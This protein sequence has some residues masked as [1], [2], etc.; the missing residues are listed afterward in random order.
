MSMEIG[1]LIIRILFGA[2]IT[3]HGAQKLFGVFGGYG[4][5][6]TG[7]FFE[8]IGFRPGKPSAAMAGL[9]EFGGGVLL[10]LGLFTPIGAAAILATMT[11]AIF[12]VHWKNGFFVTNN[13]IELPFLNATVAVGIA[14]TGAGKYSIDSFLGNNW[15]ALPY[16]APALLALALLGAIIVLATRKKA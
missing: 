1:I 12:S 15:L 11:V 10:A 4:L 14:L 13:G 3:A 7:G 9:N 5:S 2:A 6:G 16:L 8:S